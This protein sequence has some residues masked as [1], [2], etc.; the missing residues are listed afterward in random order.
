MLR[1]SVAYEAFN[2]SEAMV[3][4]VVLEDVA[5]VVVA[6][7]YQPEP[8]NSTDAN[9]SISVDVAYS[10]IARD[11]EGFYLRGL[12]V[13]VAASITPIIEEARR[14]RVG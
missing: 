4:G 14:H 6:E 1:G 13:A 3:R 7:G 11:M 2:V 5:V 9:L 10:P 8:R 12:M